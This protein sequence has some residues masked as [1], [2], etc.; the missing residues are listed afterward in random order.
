MKTD[1]SQSY[2]AS[3]L[4]YQQKLLRQVTE[5]VTAHILEAEI[6][7]IVTLVLLLL[8]KLPYFNIYLTPYITSFIIFTGIALV[9]RLSRKLLLSTAL[10][11]FF[12]SFLLLVRG[13]NDTAEEVGNLI[14]FLLWYVAVLYGR[15]IWNDLRNQSER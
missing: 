13:A 15:D 9:F 6:V 14:Y 3:F 1:K 11:L 7:G 10:F 4:A 5:Y 12:L 2:K 8:R